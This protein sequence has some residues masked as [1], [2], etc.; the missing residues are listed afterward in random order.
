MALYPSHGERTDPALVRGTRVD[1]DYPANPYLHGYGEKIPTR[2]RIQY[3][4]LHWRRVYVVQW[5]NVGSPYILHGG[6]PLFLD[7]ATEH[8]LTGN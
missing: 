3:Q 2:Y 1:S 7:A 4:T 6:T 5:G 8:R